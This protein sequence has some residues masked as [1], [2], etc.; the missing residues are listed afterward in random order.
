MREDVTIG[1]TKFKLWDF[2]TDNSKTK[3]NLMSRQKVK[4]ILVDCDYFESKPNEKGDMYVSFLVTIKVFG[5]HPYKP[6]HWFEIYYN[7]QNSKYNHINSC[8]KTTD[9]PVEDGSK[10]QQ[11]LNKILQTINQNFEEYS[12]QFI[13]CALVG[14]K[15]NNKNAVCPLFVQQ[16]IQQTRQ[17]KNKTI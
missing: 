16:A 1:D 10:E 17:Q 12:T 7:T 14:I 3:Y 8:T 9:K 4:N 13:D 2:E 6:N 5:K 15:Q 11:T